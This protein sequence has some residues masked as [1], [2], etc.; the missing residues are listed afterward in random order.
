MLQSAAVERVPSL[1]V[2]VLVAGLGLSACGK[3][4]R[5][6]VRE[7]NFNSRAAVDRIVAEVLR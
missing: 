7:I 1:I 5:Q 4:S 6:R 2:A 3:V